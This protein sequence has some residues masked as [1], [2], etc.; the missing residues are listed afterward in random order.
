MTFP[1]GI[2]TPNTQNTAAFVRTYSSVIKLR[3]LYFLRYNAL[4]NRPCNLRYGTRLLQIQA[5]AGFPNKKITKST[6]KRIFLQ[7]KRSSAV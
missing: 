1:K 3:C 6:D 5:K 4:S 7:G 2:V